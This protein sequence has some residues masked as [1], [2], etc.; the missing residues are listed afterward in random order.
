MKIY[1]RAGDKGETS[2]AS[3]KRVS[4]ADPQVDLYG[5]V[6][7]LNSRVGFSFALIDKTLQDEFLELQQL[8][9]KL[10]ELGSE[11]AGFSGQPGQSVITREDIL[12]L[13]NSIDKKDLELDKLKNFILPGGHPAAACMHLARTHCRQLE[14]RMIELHNANPDKKPE[15]IFE[16]T[17]PWINRLSDYFFICARYIN[18]K[19]NHKDI[20]WNK[21]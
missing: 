9:H 7:D 2:L 21:E 6:D 3:G 14:R 15:Y 18:L 17:L 4:K 13:E 8:Q 10:F 19:T 1:T 12:K 5:L 16:N 20:H 11:L